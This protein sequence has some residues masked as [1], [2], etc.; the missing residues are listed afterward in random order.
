[1]DTITH[2]LMGALVVRAKPRWGHRDD[3]LSPVAR[4]IT[5][6]LAAAFPDIDYVLFWWDPYQ[7]ITHWHRGLTHSVIMAPFW[8]MLLGIVFASVSGQ[9]AQWKAFSCWCALGLFCHI[10]ADIVTIYGIRFFAPISDY[11][12]ALN[13]SFDVDPWIGL[14]V[15][16][17]LVGSYYYPA[18]ARWGLM[19]VIAFLF[20]K[21][22]IQR[23]A[24][25]VVEKAVP[26]HGVMDY[27]FYAIPQPISPFHWKLVVEGDDSYK[28]AYVDL[29]KGDAQDGLFWLSAYKSKHSL[30]WDTVSHFGE[31]VDDRVIA[32]KIWNHRDFADFRQFAKLPTFYRIDRDPDGVCVWFTDLRHILP[33]LLPPFR[34]GMCRLGVQD[35]WHLYRIRR[36]TENIRQPIS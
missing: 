30:I 36:F 4:T 7:F 18:V 17:S 19:L 23:S 10:A 26:A 27:Q 34:Y 16:I 15:G 6:A 14:I 32:K 22:L 11:S 9:F 8:S 1:M 2:A 20:T 33:G 13:L 12:V 5:V 21:V 35:K 25:A 3:T 24:L 28:I 31:T 29:L